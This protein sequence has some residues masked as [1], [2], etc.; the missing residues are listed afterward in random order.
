MLKGMV[1]PGRHEDGG[2]TL[3]ELL[4]AITLLGLIATVTYSAIWTASRSQRAVEQQIEE[5]DGLRLTQEFLRH[6]L[7]Q[8]RSVMAVNEGRMQVVFS[9]ASDHLAFIAPAP[10]QRGHAGGLY[11]Y[12]LELLSRGDGHYA[13]R[14]GYAQF[15]AGRALDEEPLAQGESLLLDD[16]AALSFSYYGQD[17][18]GADAQWLDEWPR[19]DIL[20][21]LVRVTLKMAAGGESSTLTLALKGQVG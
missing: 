3:V 21:Q 12:R 5:N 2:F 8:T 19:Q 18:P 7:S 20:P 13:L 14:L 10:M 11:H 1:M 16:V 4:I 6:S 15:V 9:G 17:E